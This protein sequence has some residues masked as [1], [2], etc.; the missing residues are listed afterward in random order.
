MAGL[1]GFGLYF[2]IVPIIISFFSH[3]DMAFFCL[4]VA[5]KVLSKTIRI[6]DT[7]SKIVMLA[8]KNLN[9]EILIEHFAEKHCPSGVTNTKHFI[10][11][12]R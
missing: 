11:I 7:N 12:P 3:D 6:I 10:I 1:P 2:L 9:V 4:V 5:S 8:K